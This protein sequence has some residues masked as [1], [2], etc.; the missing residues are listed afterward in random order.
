MIKPNELSKGRLY[1]DSSGQVQ[2][3]EE[4][5]NGIVNPNIA[6]D[7]QE[8]NGDKFEDINPIPL[9]P[10][11]LGRCGFVKNGRQ[12]DGPEIENDNSISFFIIQ[13]CDMAGTYELFGSE[14]T[15]GKPFQCVHQ[16]Q[17]LYFAL[18]GEELTIK[19]PV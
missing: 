14:W 4:S 16:L 15:L 12:W 1:L 17:N 5:F 8:I 2:V 18:T 11:W 9:T 13:E 10:E 7:W 3:F 6:F 19:E